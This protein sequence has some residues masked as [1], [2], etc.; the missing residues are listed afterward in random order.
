MNRPVRLSNA[1]TVP[2]TVGMGSART[3]SQTCPTVTAQGSESAARLCA[4]DEAVGAA[5][6]VPDRKSPR[7]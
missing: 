6:A 5:P 1:R 7:H 2:V 3:R 4:S